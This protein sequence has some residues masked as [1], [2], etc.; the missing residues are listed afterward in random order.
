MTTVELASGAARATITLAGAEVRRWSVA[1]R[2]LLWPGDPA[3]WDEVSPILYPSSAG[4]ATA[5]AS[6]GNNTPL[7]CTASPGS[8]PLAWRRPAQTPSG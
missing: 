5:P 8:R 4:R 1:G 6:A 2:D 3:I 7:A